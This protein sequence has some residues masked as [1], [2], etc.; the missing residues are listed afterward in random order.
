MQSLVCTILSQQASF[1]EG[2]VRAFDIFGVLGP[3]I[4]WDAD[5]RLV[6]RE[7]VRS[8]W[9][10]TQRDLVGAYNQIVRE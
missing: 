6:D 2:F 5:P 4:D 10:M 8:D 3:S 7:A 9:E 1:W